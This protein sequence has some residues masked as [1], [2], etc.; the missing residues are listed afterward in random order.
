MGWKI[1]IVVLET[2]GGASEGWAQPDRIRQ[3]NRLGPARESEGF[4]VP[5]MGAKQNAPGGKG[6]CFV[7]ATEAEEGGEIAV[8][9]TTPEN[10]RTLQRKLYQKAK[11][12]PGYRFY[13]LYE[14]CTDRTF[15]RMPTG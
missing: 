11:Q 8:R 4:T 9:L 7:R 10:I 13:A 2:R 15:W 6:P 12:E 3:R 14:R 5:L 1:R